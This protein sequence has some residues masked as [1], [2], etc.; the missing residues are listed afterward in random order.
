MEKA[1]IDDNSLIEAEMLAEILSELSDEDKK[2]V[3]YTV[4][5]MLMLNK[6]HK[7]NE[8]SKKKR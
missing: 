6:A 4:N 3:F 7:E 8:K 2:I 5:C 1:K